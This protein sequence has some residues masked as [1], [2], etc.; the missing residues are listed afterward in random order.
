MACVAFDLRTTRRPG[1]PPIGACFGPR[2]SAPSARWT[3]AV[4][5]PYLL[6][7]SL[8]CPCLT[9]PCLAYSRLGRVRSCVTLPLTL[10]VTLPVTLPLCVC[11]RASVCV[12]VCVCVACVSV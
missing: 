12:C 3:Y 1:R 7:W 10:P 2:H 6:P 4:S 9:V 8:A 11:A 5:V